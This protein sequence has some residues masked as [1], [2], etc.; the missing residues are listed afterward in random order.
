MTLPS[1]KGKISLSSITSS[2]ITRVST[3][4]HSVLK[5]YLL[6]KGNKTLLMTKLFLHGSLINNNKQKIDI[7][8]FKLNLCNLPII[9]LLRKNLF[10]LSKS[11]MFAINLSSI[12]HFL[13]TERKHDSGDFLWLRISTQGGWRAWWSMSS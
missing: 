11:N 4:S 9:S 13:F 10:K 8:T 1:H 7:Q 6:T 2:W 5:K 12:G 3:S